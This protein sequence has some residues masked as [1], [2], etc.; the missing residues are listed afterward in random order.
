MVRQWRFPS[1]VIFCIFLTK[2]LLL[3]QEAMFLYIKLRYK[4][5][6]L[7]SSYLS[8]ARSYLLFGWH[9]AESQHLYPLENIINM[10]I[11]NI[12]WVLLSNMAL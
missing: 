1:I 12:P 9:I 4:I 5:N 10:L 11:L 7:K 8:E 2:P 6:S 3:V